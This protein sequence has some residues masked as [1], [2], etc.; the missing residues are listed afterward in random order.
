MFEKFMEL[1]N[2]CGNDVNC[3]LYH[4]YYDL[5]IEDSEGFDENWCEIERDFENQN[6][7]ENLLDWLDE[8]ASSIIGEYSPIYHFDGFDVKVSYSSQDL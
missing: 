1:V 5:T 8:N 4:G 3:D 7:V 6:A 2:A